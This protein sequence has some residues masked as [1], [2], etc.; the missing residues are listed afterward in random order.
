MKRKY[1]A[2][3]TSNVLILDPYKN[4][5]KLELEELVY[6]SKNYWEAMNLRGRLKNILGQHLG[7]A[8]KLIKLF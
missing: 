5:N 1:F 7:R 2:L 3:G 6:F 8:L 4:K